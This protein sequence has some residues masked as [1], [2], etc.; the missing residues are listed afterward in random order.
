MEVPQFP[1]NIFGP[2]LIRYGQII[3]NKPFVDLNS[4]L[5]N[6]EFAPVKLFRQ[7]FSDFEVEDEIV[8]I[9]LDGEE[10]DQML[11]NHF[12]I[13]EWFLFLDYDD[14]SVK[15][16]LWAIDSVLRYLNTGYA[17]FVPVNVDF[18]LTDL[19]LIERKI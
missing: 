12:P 10:Y 5:H 15:M 4:Y 13:S 1:R 7:L 3:P 2:K 17:H 11:R 6:N 19:R 16:D 14:I 9:P 18:L 8:W